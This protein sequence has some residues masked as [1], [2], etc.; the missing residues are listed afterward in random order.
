MGLLSEW[1]AQPQALGRSDFK[2]APNFRPPCVLSGPRCGS[3][4]QRGQIGIHR[5]DRTSSSDKTT[6]SLCRSKVSA[7]RHRWSRAMW[8]VGRLIG[9]K[10]RAL[11]VSAM[12]G[13][14]VG[15]RTPQR[16]AVRLTTRSPSP[17]R[18][19]AHRLQHQPATLSTQPI[20]PVPVSKEL[21]LTHKRK[22]A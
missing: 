11:A 14:N 19:L 18:R 8:A 4:R 13:S 16:P 17:H 7:S 15:R 2:Q 9:E 3:H 12:G 22:V 20:H 5:F 1:L 6:S 21:D 10:C